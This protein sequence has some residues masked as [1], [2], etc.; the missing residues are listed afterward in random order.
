MSDPVSRRRFLVSAGAVLGVGPLLAACGGGGDVTA[1]SC[2]GYAALDAAAL[3][4]R[5]SL[6]YVD[7]SATPGQLCSNCRFYNAPAAGA[8]CGGCQL[9]QGP[10]A[11]GGWCKSWVAMTA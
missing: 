8:D 6:E 4:Q 9:F 10:V 11:P 2:E 1:A 3:Q 5:A 7:K